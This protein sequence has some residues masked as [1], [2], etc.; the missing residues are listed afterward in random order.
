[1]LIVVLGWSS[2]NQLG[3]SSHFLPEAYSS[4]SL[5]TLRLLFICPLCF[6][7]VFPN[8]SICNIFPI[9]RSYGQGLALIE[10][11]NTKINDYGANMSHVIFN[12]TDGLVCSL[13]ESMYRYCYAEVFVV[14]AWWTKITSSNLESKN[15]S[16][17][18]C[19]RDVFSQRIE[20]TYEVSLSTSILE[21]SYRYFCRYFCTAAHKDVVDL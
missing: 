9:L 5:K 12:T 16:N 2:E 13:L 15:C 19:N 10:H 8:F 17:D 6:L 21:Q 14:I 1:M 18:Y 4:W 20:T 11:C 3:R 7:G